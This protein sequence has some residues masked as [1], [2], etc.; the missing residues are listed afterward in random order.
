MLNPDVD[1][2]PLTG[3]AA[4]WTVALLLALSASIAAVRL[5][6]ESPAP[7]T[8]AVYDMSGAVM[9][10]VRL[11]LEGEGH[12]TLE[13]R[14]D[15]AGRFSFPAV[16]PGAY[17]LQASL[18]GF[19]TLRYELTLREMRDWTQVLTLQVGE[20]VETVSVEASREAPSAPG[21]EAAAPRLK[22]GGA[23]RPPKKIKDVHARYPEAMKKAGQ[24]GAVSLAAVIGRDGSVI[25][26]HVLSANIHPDLAAAAVEAV[27]QWRFEPT[28]LNGAP[29]EVAMTVT[30]NFTLAD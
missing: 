19:R 13:T 11:T 21:P 1:R 4:A 23:I 5:P 17:V 22:V 15:Q 25:A 16:A 29:V 7:L 8:G 12:Q 6:Q 14:T 18:A 26:V 30:V 10:D 20:V 24:Q 3:H 9:P 2:R 27:R 28:L